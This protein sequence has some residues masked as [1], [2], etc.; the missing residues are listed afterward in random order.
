MRIA[1]T[2]VIVEDNVNTVA[3]DRHHPAIA[4]GQASSVPD[5]WP[6]GWQ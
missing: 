5:P 1:V 6:G 2:I 4:H 3:L